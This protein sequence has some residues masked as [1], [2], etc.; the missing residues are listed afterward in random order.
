MCAKA[1]PA[2]G[3][4]LPVGPDTLVGCCPGFQLRDGDW[5][6]AVHPMLHNYRVTALR[7][8]GAGAGA[9]AGA[10]RV[11]GGAGGPV[12]GVEWGMVEPGEPGGRGGAFHPSSRVRWLTGRM[13]PAAAVAARMSS[14][15][16]GGSAGGAGAA[17]GSAGGAT[18]PTAPTVAVPR[19]ELRVLAAAGA[20]GRHRALQLVVGGG[21][22]EGEGGGEGDS[23]EGE[24]APF[25]PMGTPYHDGPRGGRQPRSW[26]DDS[27]SD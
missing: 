3:S 21:D 12:L 23:G 15:G 1:C 5:R 6:A 7:L 11:R 20:S 2:A 18:L 24:G 26:A 9:G 14:A 27:D 19:P 25:T 16:N 22:D 13:F 17:A 4:L 8:D 10:G